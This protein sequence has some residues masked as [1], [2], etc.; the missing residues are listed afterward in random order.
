VLPVFQRVLAEETDRKLRL[1]ADHGLKR[2][3][4]AGIGA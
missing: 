3:A 4:L 1:H 2:Y